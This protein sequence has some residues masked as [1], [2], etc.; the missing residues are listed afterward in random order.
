VTRT[1]DDGELPAFVVIYRTPGGWR[2]SIFTKGSTIMCG[3]LNEL[4]ADADLETAQLEANGLV[5]GMAVERH[6]VGLDITWRP[7]DKLGWSS[8]T[9]IRLDG[10]PI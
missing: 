10:K 3:H 2:H 5:S 9:V 8:G 7:A 1:T 4:P 6:G